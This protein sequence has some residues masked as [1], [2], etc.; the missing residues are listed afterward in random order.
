MEAKG[1]AK[2]R[3]RALLITLTVIAAAVIAAI[4]LGVTERPFTD[5]AAIDADVV[6]V[7]PAVGGRVISLPV[8]ENQLVRRKIRSSNWTRCPTS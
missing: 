1:Q 8:H 7:A 2:P 4:A 5:D 3:R 6:H